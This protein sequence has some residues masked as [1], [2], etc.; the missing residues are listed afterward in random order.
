MVTFDSVSL[1]RGERDVEGSMLY[2]FEEF[3]AAMRLLEEGI[4]PDSVV[5]AGLVRA[6]FPV[7]RAQEAF[8]LLASGEA[9]VLKL[10]LMHQ[11]G[12]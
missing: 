2:T 7:D 3:I 11:A 5:E 6:E 1:Q 9:P 8:E 12:D 10:V 4:V